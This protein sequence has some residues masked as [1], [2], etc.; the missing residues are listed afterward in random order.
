MERRKT[1]LVERQTFVA[2]ALFIRISTD[3]NKMYSVHIVVY[4]FNLK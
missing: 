3:V 2:G 1:L 4:F